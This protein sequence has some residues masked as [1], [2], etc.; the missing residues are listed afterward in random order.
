MGPWAG[1]KATLFAA[2]FA[3]NRLA[4]HRRPGRCAGVRL[5]S[6]AQGQDNSPGR[7][8]SPQIEVKQ[9]VVGHISILVLI[10][11]PRLALVFRKFEQA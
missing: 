7:L 11:M 5:R 3:A 10:A 6:Q 1:T 9:H 2:H 8:F 4:N